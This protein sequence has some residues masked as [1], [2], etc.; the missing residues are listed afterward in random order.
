M[1]DDFAL[2]IA[3]RHVHQFVDDSESLLKRNAQGI[4][5]RECEDWLRAGIVSARWLRRAEEFLREADYQGLR[6]FDALTQESLGS[7]YADWLRSA[8]RA[9]T[10]I[11]GLASRGCVP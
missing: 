11:D 2:A 6:P 9:D 5:C 10:L 7:L 1:S 4:E 3:Q 8:E